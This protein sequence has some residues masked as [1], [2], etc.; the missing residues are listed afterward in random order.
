MAAYGLTSNFL[1]LL[2][3]PNGNRFNIWKLVNLFWAP[4]V[5]GNKRV[6]TKSPN[7]LF[8]SNNKTRRSKT[9]K[10][11]TLASSRCSFKTEFSK[12]VNPLS[13]DGKPIQFKCK[14]SVNENQCV[15]ISVGIRRCHDLQKQV[16]L[17][18]GGPRSRSYFKSKKEAKKLAK[19]IWMTYFAG[20]G[21]VKT[22]PFLG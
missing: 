19:K 16:L 13:L 5:I 4:C 6:A 20:Q 10:K 8:Q 18:I 2:S 7:Q 1:L 14:G 11:Y 12:S 9:D 3:P 15:D 22:R 21:H 17:G